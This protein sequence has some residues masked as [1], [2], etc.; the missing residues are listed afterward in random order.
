MKRR[1]LIALAVGIPLSLAS[2]TATAQNEAPASKGV[3]A[4]T[5][6]V[7]PGPGQVLRVTIDWGDGS[8]EAVVRFRRI[9]YSQ[10]A[11]NGG[12]CL[13]SMSSQTTFA[14]LTLMPGEGA[15]M[16]I[17]DTAFGVRGVVFSNRPD[18]TATAQTINTSTG[19]VTSHVIMAN[20]EGDFH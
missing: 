15:S 11:C 9:E 3:M 6:I 19:E 10:G 2:L 20:T 18:L 14:P 17:G 4:D 13:L 12:V 8:G 5:G 16:D 7:R 1:I